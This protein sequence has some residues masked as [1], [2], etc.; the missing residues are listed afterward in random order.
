MEWFF[1][2]LAFVISVLI[3]GSAVYAL[4]WSSKHGQLRDFDKGALSIFDENEP[5]GKPTDSFPG[6]SPRKATPTPSA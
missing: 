2:A 3:T 6:K 1:Y 4:Q 5:V